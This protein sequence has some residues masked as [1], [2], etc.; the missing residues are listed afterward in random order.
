[1]SYVDSTSPHHGDVQGGRC[2]RNC[3]EDRTAWFCPESQ[4]DIMR[5]LPSLMRRYLETVCTADCEE[6]EL[7]ALAVQPFERDCGARS[8][9]APAPG[10]GEVGRWGGGANEPACKPG[11]YEGRDPQELPQVRGTLRDHVR[12][13]VT[14]M[15][16]EVP[17]LVL[18][19]YP[20]AAVSRTRLRTVSTAAWSGSASRP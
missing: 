14:R 13:V 18:A 10:S 20:T 19:R 6:R 12:S 1:M 2:G 9:G 16:Q 5:R 7:G 17:W 4:A 15:S 8:C 3:T 11:R